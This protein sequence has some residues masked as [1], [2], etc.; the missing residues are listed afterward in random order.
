[1]K[2]KTL[3]TTLSL[4][5]V[6]LFSSC[7]N[8]DITSSKAFDTIE[9]HLTDKPEYES[10][11]INLGKKKLRMRKDSVQIE[12]YKSLE[13]EGYIEF[14]EE[15]A[16]KKWLSKDSIWN[17]TLKLTEKAHPY[18]IEQKNDRVTV[19]TILYTLGNS[20]SLQLN[21][22]SKKSATA[23]VMLNKEYTP[24]IT[25]AKDRNPNTKFITK[26]YKLRFSEE[27]GWTIN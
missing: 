11:I 16:K 10:T 13:K 6:I 18:V 17:V 15:N 26:K 12:Q 8:K 3:L 4:F 9:S 23:S 19:K 20:S 24:F 5:C 2:T 7:N 1:M 14:A 22:R 21:N 25:L 27:N